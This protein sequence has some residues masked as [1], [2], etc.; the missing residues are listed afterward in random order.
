[1]RI[2]SAGQSHHRSLYH[3]QPFEGKSK[4]YLE[5]TLRDRTIYL[6]P[7]QSFNDPWDCRPWFN[8]EGLD[9]TEIKEAH[10]QWFMSQSNQAK[11]S[12]A[13]E[14]RENPELLRY[15]VEEC[16]RGLCEELNNQYRV[17]C[18][19][20][21]DLNPLMW[22][23]Y[24]DKHKGVCLQFDTRIFPL[25]LALKVEYQENL[26]TV[27]VT[28]NN[29]DPAVRVLFTKSDVWKYEEEFRLLARDENYPLPDTPITSKNFLSLP[30]RALVGIILGCQ[31]EAGDEI[32]DMVERYQ[33]QLTVKKAVRAP[34]R[35]GLTL[36]TIY[37]RR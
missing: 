11:D 30:D 28:E 10:I 29:P 5:A 26:P 37:P 14:M 23:H 12:D 36:E 4:A 22:S 6:P 18:L 27:F 7:P 15:M 16:S 9:N 21:H 3:Y 1:M 33:P 34:H 19:T 20:P 31:S 13:N 32:I 2:I 24:S 17:Y 8:L 35:Y 25:A